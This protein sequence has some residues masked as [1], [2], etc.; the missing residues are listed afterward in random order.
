M[1]LLDLPAPL[2]ALLDAGLSG[3]APPAVRLAVWGLLAAILSMGL[4]WLLSPQGR[5][6]EAKVQAAAAR[7]ALD[8]YDGEFAGAWPLI[9][10]MLRLAVRQLALVT[11]PAVAASLP[12]LALL[13]WLSTAY[14]HAFPAAPS[15]V[16]VHTVP[17]HFQAWL[18]PNGSAA[19][20]AHEVVVRDA[21]G[22][23]VDQV[24]IA[25]PVPT[26]H[27]RQWWNALLGNP[28]GYLPDQAV[29]ERIEVELPER[30]Y[31]PMG[32]DWLRA[33][34]AVFFAALLAGSIAIKVAARIE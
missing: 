28:A 7:R 10:A 22:R 14:G 30:Q 9:R 31:L 29:L 13:V 3:I 6:A 18:Q 8:A 5:I 27:K 23:I 1:G 33:W 32:P 16:S 24:P 12:V 25:V 21:D 4:Y 19:S 11:G 15:A 17:E 26:I 2:F 34:Y 20:A